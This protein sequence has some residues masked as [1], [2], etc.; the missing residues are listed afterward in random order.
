[1]TAKVAAW[2]RTALVLAL[3]LPVRFYQLYLRPLLPAVCRFYPSCS[4]YFLQAV[5][6]YGPVAGAWRGFVRFCRCHPWSRGGYDP[7]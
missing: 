4:E 2:G 5:E 1:M 6:K 3:V 7:P